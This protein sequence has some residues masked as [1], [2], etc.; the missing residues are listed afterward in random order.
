MSEKLITIRFNNYRQANTL[1]E[2]SQ[3]EVEFRILMD[4]AMGKVFELVES[5]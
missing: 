1:R 3:Y 5:Q 4:T 2:L